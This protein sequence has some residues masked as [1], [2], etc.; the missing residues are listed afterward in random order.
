MTVSQGATTIEDG[1]TIELA[2]GG[3]DCAGCARSVEQGLRAVPGVRDVRVLLQ[4]ERATVTLDPARV[5][6]QQLAEAVVAAGYTVRPPAQTEPDAAPA[7]G[8]GGGVGAALGGGLFLVAIVVVL[9]VVVGEQIGLFGAALEPLPWWVPALAVAVGGWP[10]FRD[11]LRAARRRQVTSHTLMT[12]G[13]IAAIAIGE[14][15]TAALIVFFMRFAAWLEARTTERGRQA[16]RELVALQSAVARVRREGQ[17]VEIPAAAVRVGDVVLVRPGER[18]PADGVVISGQAPVDQSTITGESAPVT[19]GVGDP[20]SAATIVQAGA[21]QVSVT[22]VGPDTTF[23]RIVRLVEEAETHKAPVQRFA[24]RF[25]TWYL[26]LILAIAGLTFLI[27][28]AVLNAVA[29]LVVACAC[30]I[31]I[32]TPVVILASTGQAARRGLLIKGGLTL[33]Q[34][35][36]VTTVVFDKTGTVTA[37]RPDLTEILAYH[38]RSPDDVLARAA[39]VER[40]SEH[41]LGQAL[42]RGAADRGIRLAEPASFAVFPG[43]GVSGEIAGETWLGGNRR[44]LAGH[45]IALDAEMERDAQ[46]FETAGATAFFLASPDRVEGILAVTDVIRPAVAPALAELRRLGVTNLLLLTGDNERVAAAVAG[47]LGVAYQAGLLPEDKI[48]AIRRLQASGQVVMMVGDGVNDAPALMQA[49][50]GVAMGAGSDVSLEAAGVALM[51]DDWRM[52]PEA[53]RIGR[54][55][56]RTIRQNLGFAAAYNVI[57]VTL[58]AVGVLPPVWAAAAQSL[59]DVAIML[60]SSRLLRPGQAGRPAE[61]LPETLPGGQ[62]VPLPH[63]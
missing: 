6:N 57:G 47:E 2:I 4:A 29:V 9:A 61:P 51:R 19:R 1:Q 56:V 14:W 46:R 13:A 60:N 40:Q 17:E 24:D 3:M 49:D 26:P 63:A 48:A 42:V 44:L 55:S 7:R 52:V 15:T 8:R 10:I 20:V 32:A 43:R 38:G 45:A 34:L 35:A 12:V 33:E 58:A 11:V 25:A 21:V 53:I 27:T 23:G 28:G 31:A 22:A 37:G 36:R 16:L 59:P 30:A 39:A 62:S 5:T 54:R 18:I 50:V 41:P